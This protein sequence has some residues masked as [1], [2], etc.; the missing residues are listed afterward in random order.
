MAQA[1]LAHPEPHYPVE[2]QMAESWLHLLVRSLLLLLTRRLLETR[3][4]RAFVGSDQFLYWVRGEP[5]RVIAPDLY[6]L[7]GMDPDAAARSWKLWEAGRG[8]QP[9]RRSRQ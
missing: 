2:D 6:V 8:A 1:T 3:G 9:G 7:P 5:Q 4:V